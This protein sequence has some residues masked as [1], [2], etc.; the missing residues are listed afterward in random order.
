MKKLFVYAMISMVLIASALALT[1]GTDLELRDKADW[2]ETPVVQKFVNQDPDPAEPGQYVE[3]RWKIENN[4]D[5][6]ANNVIVELIPEYPFSLDPNQEAVQRIGSLTAGQNTRDA[7]IVKYKVRV[8][9]DAVEGDNE[10]RLRYR[11]GSYEWIE[12]EFAVAVQTRDASLSIEK[13]ETYPQNLVPGK[14]ANIKIHVKNLADSVIK[15]VTLKLDLA[16]ST[17]TMATGETGNAAY[18]DLLPFAPVNSATEKRI[19]YVNPGETAI[20]EYEII[21]YPDAESRVYKIPIQLK[22]YD[23]LEKE[24]TKNDI[25]GISVGDEPEMTMVVDGQTI[26]GEGERGEV[27]VKIVNMGTNDL[28]F[29]NMIVRP[30]EDFELFG[31]DSIYIGKVDSD[32]YETVSLDIFVKDIKDDMLVLPLELKYRDSNNNEFFDEVMLAVDMYGSGEV[33]EYG[34]R[35]SSP[36]VGF[37]IIIVIVVVGI[38]AYRYCK[39]KKC[40]NGK[41][42]KSE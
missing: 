8:D 19:R 31:P 30:S 21:A 40:L 11:W 34:L 38:F 28:K 37:L 33:K 36:I 16:L 20:F 27:L 9:K 29:M 24:Y 26:Y 17:V 18:S 13:I 2:D 14:T 15:D 42:K 7:V 22:Y 35:Q 5:E 39:K 1:A 41:K 10:I 6:T 4:G 25:I 23:E 12:E 32:D 3:L